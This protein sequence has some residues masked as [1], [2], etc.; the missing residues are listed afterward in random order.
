MHV[1][2]RIARA[3]LYA[4]ALGDY[5]LSIKWQTGWGRINFNPGWPEIS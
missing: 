4:S 3:M 1:E 5:V 2:K